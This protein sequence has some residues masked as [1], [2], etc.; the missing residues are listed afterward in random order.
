MQND[1]NLSDNFLELKIQFNEIEEFVSD[2]M[3][4]LF[5]SAIKERDYVKAKVV[6]EKQKERYF[7][8]ARIYNIDNN[9][10]S[11]KKDLMKSYI[12]SCDIDSDEQKRLSRLNNLKA[13]NNNLKNKVNILSAQNKELEEKN[14]EFLNK[15]KAAAIEEKVPGYVK[16]Q[17]PV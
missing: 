2:D 16:K 10:A 7:N 12:K 15:T 4:K 1:D 8:L 17:H 6:L 5:Y 3:K 13:E 14:K 11:I 9:R